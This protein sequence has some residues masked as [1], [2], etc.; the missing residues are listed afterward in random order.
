M[1]C[2]IHVVHA[3]DLPL[4]INVAVGAVLADVNL[5]LGGF[6]IDGVVK[7]DGVGVLQTPVSP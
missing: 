4:R 3:N 6:L 5:I 1:S 2:D 7:V